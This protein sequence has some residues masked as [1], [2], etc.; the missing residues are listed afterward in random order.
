M[1]LS[2]RTLKRMTHSRLPISRIT[3]TGMTLSRI[4]HNRMALSIMT[5]RRMT[6]II[7]PLGRKILSK[8]PPSRINNFTDSRMV[9][10]EIL[11]VFLFNVAQTNVVAPRGTQQHV[12]RVLLGAKTLSIMTVRITTVSITTLSITTA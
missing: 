6:Q 10:S 7:M 11:T 1:T 5:L 9:L 2:R 12:R 8:T 3:I 4:T